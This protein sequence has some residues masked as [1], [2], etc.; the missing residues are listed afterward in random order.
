[1]KVGATIPRKKGNH[2]QSSVDRPERHKAYL[3][4]KPLPW[5][6]EEDHVIKRKPASVGVGQV[7]GFEKT[8]F[9]LQGDEKPEKF[10]LWKQDIT[11]KIVTKNP[12]WDSIWPAM[13]DLTAKSASTTVYDV[14]HELNIS[15]NAYV[16]LTYPYLLPFRN[17]A[18]KKK[19]TAKATNNDGTVMNLVDGQTAWD[20]FVKTDE[21]NPLLLEEVMFRLEELIFGTDMI[22]RNAYYLLR[23]LI[24]FYKIDPNRGIKEWQIRVNQ[25]NG[26]SLDVPCDSLERRNMPREQFD[27]FELREVLDFAMSISYSQKLFNLDWNTYEHSFAET[28]DKLVTIEPEIKAETAKAKADKDLKEKVYGTQGVKR[29][30]DGSAKVTDA[31]KSTCKHCGKLH[32]GECWN[33][34]GSGKG[35][36]GRNNKGKAFNK[37][38]MN[39]INSMFKTHSSTK[40]D[41]GFSDNESDEGDWKKGISTVHQMYIAMQYRQDN[42]LDDDDNIQEID[43][44]SLKDYV[45]K[46]KRAEKS[47]KKS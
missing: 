26:Y 21:I 1:M 10:I 37:Q 16:K 22:G 42:G 32:K 47:L 4:L 7:A 12:D 9:Q 8:F 15:E 45:K 29:N 31:N 24:R 2:S 28:V 39:Q 19:L 13:L 46:A 25:L 38:Q 11:T 23:K 36:A 40:N 18:T 41:S 34:N 43:P 3:T 30:K 14:F 27:E 33:K 44:D 17:L 6:R 35:N 20:A 5:D